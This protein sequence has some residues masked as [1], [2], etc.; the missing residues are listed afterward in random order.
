MAERVAVEFWS[1]STRPG[2]YLESLLRNGLKSLDGYSE[3]LETKNTSAARS[4]GK[5][6]M[7][8]KIEGKNGVCLSGCSSITE[9]ARIMGPALFERASVSDSSNYRLCLVLEVW[10]SEVWHYLEIPPK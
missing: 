6:Q 4:Q 8:L 2:K 9:V 1:G 7:V 10:A 3:R 5:P